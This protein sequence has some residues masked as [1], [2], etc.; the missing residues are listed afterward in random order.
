MHCKSGRLLLIACLLLLLLSR[1]TLA[2]QPYTSPIGS[3]KSVYS[4]SRWSVET[5]LTFPMVRIYMLKLS[6]R[7]SD[8]TELGFGPAFQN[9]KNTDESFVGQANAYTLVLSYRHYF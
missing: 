7:H 6:Y 2:R 1:N 3:D 9:W 4:E 5:S 8:R